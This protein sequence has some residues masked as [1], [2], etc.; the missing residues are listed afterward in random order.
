MRSTGR[1]TALATAFLLVAAV[2][3]LEAASGAAGL[4]R[5]VVVVGE[6]LVVLSPPPPAGWGVVD[7]PEL[8]LT[9]PMAV[10]DAPVPPPSPAPT[11][12][13]ARQ[14]L[15]LMEENDV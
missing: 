15:I 10:R 9:L 5:E 13:G 8:D 7:L 2:T 14:V 3:G 1:V 4:D 6:D 11:A 12:P